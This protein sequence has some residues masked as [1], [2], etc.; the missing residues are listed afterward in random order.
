KPP[1]EFRWASYIHKLL[2][3]VHPELQVSTDGL[4]VLSDALDELMERLASECQHLVQ[5]NDRATLTAR[6]VE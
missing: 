6:D 5:T 4:T 1:R 2:Q 3:Q